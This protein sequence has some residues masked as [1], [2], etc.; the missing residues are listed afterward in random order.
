MIMTTKATVVILAMLVAQTTAVTQRR[1]GH[2]TMRRLM[3]EIA[4]AHGGSRRRLSAEYLERR[5]LLAEGEILMESFFRKKKLN[6]KNGRKKKT[7]KPSYLYLAKKTDGEIKLYYGKPEDE[8]KDDPGKTFCSK[9]KFKSGK[10]QLD[11][12][13]LKIYTKEFL[14]K[15]FA[16]KQKAKVMTQ[17][18]LIKAFSEVGNSDTVE[19]SP[20]DLVGLGVC[21]TTQSGNPNPGI[22]IFKF[23]GIHEAAKWVQELRKA[24]AILNDGKSDLALA[25]ENLHTQQ[26]A[27]VEENIAARQTQPQSACLDKDESETLWMS[28]NRNDSQISAQSAT[29]EMA[30]FINDNKNPFSTSPLV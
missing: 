14:P 24:R 15:E 13:N 21:E 29:T 9:I 8:V 5:D 16:D 6:A 23:H 28:R 18:E 2:P 30:A 26:K 1:S 7:A 11:P 10:G 20:K 19:D 22:W 4:R 25:Q 27:K 17:T 12:R 3:D